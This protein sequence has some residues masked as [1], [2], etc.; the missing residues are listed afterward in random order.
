LG[1]EEDKDNVRVTT[2]HSKIYISHEPE[3]EE[4]DKRTGLIF[5]KEAKQKPTEARKRNRK[6][7]SGSTMDTKFD[8]MKRTILTLQNQVAKL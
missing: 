6:I 5:K 7:H 3:E 1:K 8:E 4:R 2:E